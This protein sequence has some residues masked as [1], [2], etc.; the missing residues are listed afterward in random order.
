MTC[1][2]DAVRLPEGDNGHYKDFLT[3]E[4]DCYGCR[5]VYFPSRVF[6]AAVICSSAMRASMSSTAISLG[7]CR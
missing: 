4:K 5:A 7:I 6:S 1:Q 2:A 3:L